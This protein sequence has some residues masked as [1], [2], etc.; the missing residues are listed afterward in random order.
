MG[1]F[2]N[3][4]FKY[5]LG[6]L[7]PAVSS[8][9][10]AFTNEKG[11]SF[12]NWIGRNW[13]WAAAIL[14]VI[15]LAADL[16]IYLIRWRPYKVWKSFFSGAKDEADEP[17]EIPERRRK[18]EGR[19][20]ADTGRQPGEEDTEPEDIPEY[21]QTDSCDEPETAGTGTVRDT[22]V[23]AMPEKE[24]AV[25]AAAVQPQPMRTGSAIGAGYSVPDDSPYRR[26][27]KETFHENLQETEQE[28]K[29]YSA[30]VKDRTDPMPVVPRRRRRINVAELFNDPEEE[31]RQFDAPQHV[32][33]S[34]KAY[35]DPVY[36][37]G[38]NKSEDNEA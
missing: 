6:W 28:K 5:M 11:N 35:R 12:F 7:Q 29:E 31:I 37:R 2:A 3:S 1:S 24:E 26:P 8:V 9:W 14:C 23:T 4:L 34:R 19:T 30:S 20:E 36:P 13:I 18:G 38:W 27:A 25:T 16:C 10:S 22:P 21:V 32:I 33:D 17:A 15:G